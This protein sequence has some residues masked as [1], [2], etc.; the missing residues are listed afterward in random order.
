MLIFG[1]VSKLLQKLDFFFADRS[2]W[3]P[4][5]WHINQLSILIT[6]I[7]I[8][9]CELW[10]PSSPLLLAFVAPLLF[11][12]AFEF[13]DYLPV[14]STYSSPFIDQASLGFSL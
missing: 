11:K 12:F 8:F 10:P 14:K 13:F 1:Y 6:T 9:L 7:F 3:S 4:H 2:A 5:L